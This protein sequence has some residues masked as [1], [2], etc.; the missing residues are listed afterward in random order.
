MSELIRAFWMLCTGLPLQYW[1]RLTQYCEEAHAY[2][3]ATA[4]A[5]ADLKAL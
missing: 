1:A 4:L 2:C 5:A 3:A